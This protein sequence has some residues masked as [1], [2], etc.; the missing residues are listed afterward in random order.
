MPQ[1]STRVRPTTQTYAIIHGLAEGSFI[2]RNLRQA[3]ATAGFQPAAEQVADIIITH[4]GGFFAL[5]KH[6]KAKLFLHINPSYWPGKPL[7]KST[8]EKITYDFRLHRQRH[9]LKQ[10][11]LSSGANLIYMLN[12]RHG[13]RML[14]GVAHRKSRFTH[15]PKSNHIF[16]RTH[17]DNY[18][19]PYA[20]LKAIGNKHTYLTLAGHHDDC[21][22]EPEPYVRLMQSL[23]QS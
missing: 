17:R 21:W 22:R 4:S 9:Q 11:W 2:S 19:D 16:V 1:T 3:L 6:S 12:I 5:P 15:L 7:Y 20:L 10:W 13:L 18:C 14:A 8:R 23:R